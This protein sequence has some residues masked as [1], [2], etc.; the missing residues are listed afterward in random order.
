MRH[1][2]TLLAAALF[3]SACSD[4]QPLLPDAP[5]PVE[6][7]TGS[8]AAVQEIVDAAYVVTPVD[9]SEGITIGVLDEG[10]TERSALVSF[11][12]DREWQIVRFSKTGGKWVPATYVRSGE[13]TTR[14]ASATGGATAA[15]DGYSGRIAR[16]TAWTNSSYVDEWYV[17]GL[18]VPG[19][20]TQMENYTG[21]PMDT[22][23]FFP[24]S[25]VVNNA[26]YTVSL[27]QWSPFRNTAPA[28]TWTSTSNA[29]RFNTNIYNSATNSFG[30]YY[31]EYWRVSY[32]LGV[33]PPP[34]A[35]VQSQEANDS[36]YFYL[37]AAVTGQAAG[38]TVASYYWETSTDNAT[39]Q[40]AGNTQRIGTFPQSTGSPKF[41]AR[42]RITLSNGQSDLSDSTFI[43][44]WS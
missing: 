8:A 42:V 32:N 23:E 24:G 36:E 35:S 11:E 10:R 39:W 26:I 20:Y 3:L 4:R 31:P 21:L 7:G 16:I 12:N 2:S 28:Y 30:T 22:G 33:T 29:V 34:T 44:W 38:T 41:Y 5:A 13:F 25:M 27:S 14:R 6:Q 43:G 9:A 40:Y 19:T 17:S 37:S 1:L 18:G 15:A